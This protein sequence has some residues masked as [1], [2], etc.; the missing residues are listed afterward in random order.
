MAWEP[1]GVAI[2]VYDK[3]NK[4]DTGMTGR[5]A[6]RGIGNLHAFRVMRLGASLM[7]ASLA[8]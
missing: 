5:H 1:V 4:T 6:V 2:G 7:L 8:G 3:G